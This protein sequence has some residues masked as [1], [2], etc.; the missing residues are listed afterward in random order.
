M[1]STQRYKK[2]PHILV[3]SKTGTPETFKT[4]QPQ[5][6]LTTTQLTMFLPKN[7]WME[8]LLGSPKCNM[9]TA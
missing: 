9:K 7:F 1:A 5:N 2:L 6:H 3:N 4:A 8:T